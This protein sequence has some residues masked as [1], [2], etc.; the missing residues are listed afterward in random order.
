M[1]KNKILLLLAISALGWGACNKSSTP[2]RTDTPTS[3]V[4]QVISDENIAK[5]IAEQV[6]VFESEYDAAQIDL[7]VG[8]EVDVINN[9]LKDS[10]RLAFAYRELTAAEKATIAERKRRLRS[11]KVAIDGIALIVNKANTDTL[12]SRKA[13]V[14]I[15]TGKISKWNEVNPV[16]KSGN[17]NEI[18]FVFDNPSSSTVR[19]LK[20][21]LAGGVALAKHLK[22]LSSSE[23]VLNFV[24][25][26]KNALGV[27]GVNWISNPHDSLH[28][29][30]NDK[31]R[32]M[33]VS[34]NHPAFADES[35]KPYPAYLALG[36]YPLTRSVYMLLTDMHGGLPS[37]FAHFV[38]GDKGQRI[39][40]KSGLVPG[41]R[42]MRVVSLKEKL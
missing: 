41:T 25:E 21:T 19:Y 14:D 23:E 9:L 20:D 35:Y 3:G 28:L 11:Q 18:R 37:G 27:I 24:S 17:T 33:S 26:N 15:L 31:I 13:L 10:I 32:V 1:L 2:K 12:I 4:A 36:K 30:F 40:L 6:V 7:V 29:S 38:G 39:V 22:S 8:N 16:A 34:L 42:P 5:V